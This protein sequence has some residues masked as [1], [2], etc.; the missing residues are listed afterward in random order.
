M[1]HACQSPPF[2]RYVGPTNGGGSG[3]TG[4]TGPTGA[5]GATGATG[6]AGGGSASPAG[7][8]VPPIVVSGATGWTLIGS[9][10]LDVTLIGADFGL[11]S[12]STI[13]SANVAMLPGF[14]SGFEIRAVDSSGFVVTTIVGAVVDSLPH[15]YTA[16]T[17]GLAQSF[18]LVEARCLG[19]GDSLIVYSSSV[20]STF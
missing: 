13:L 3:S 5:T 16:L 8:V 7:T 11:P 17:A 2:E 14:T 4:P 18:F 15:W 1:S 10:D 20:W 19:A 9:V 12:V 6:P